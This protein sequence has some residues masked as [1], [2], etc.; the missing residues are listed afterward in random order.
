M[1]DKQGRALAQRLPAASCQPY[2]Q[3]LTS[4]PANPL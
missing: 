4:P 3:V 1:G 2:F